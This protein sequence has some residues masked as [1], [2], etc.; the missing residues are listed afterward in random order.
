MGYGAVVLRRRSGTANWVRIDE[1]PIERLEP[2]T[3]HT[4]RVF[5]AEDYLADLKKQRRY[6]RDVY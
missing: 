4:L 1:I 2:A 5:A 3:E 6:Q